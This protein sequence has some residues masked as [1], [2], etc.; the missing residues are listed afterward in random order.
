MSSTLGAKGVPP[1]RRSI[2]HNHRHAIR[3]S[4]RRGPRRRGNGG[5]TGGS[6]TDNR[7]FTSCFDGLDNAGIRPGDGL[8]NAGIRPGD[9]LHEA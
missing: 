2:E 3:A 6:S 9:G 5:V 1:P 8:D 7:Y 4:H